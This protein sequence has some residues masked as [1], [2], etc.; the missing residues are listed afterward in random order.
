MTSRPGSFF[1]PQWGT[2][3]VGRWRRQLE[4]NLLVTVFAKNFHFNENWKGLVCILKYIITFYA[5]SHKSSARMDTRNRCIKCCVTEGF[6]WKQVLLFVVVFHSVCYNFSYSEPKWV[7]LP[8]LCFPCLEAALIDVK[9]QETT[10]EE[11]PPGPLSPKLLNAKM[12]TVSLGNKYLI[13]NRTEY[14][15]CTHFR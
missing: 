11:A 9:S 8:F 7:T 4:P 3:V 6:S 2:T 13:F 15:I 10:L 5:P 12:G 14:S 1:K